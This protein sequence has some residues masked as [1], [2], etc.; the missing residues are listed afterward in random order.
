MRQFADLCLRP[1]SMDKPRI[2]RII[3][4]ASELGFSLVGISL[5]AKA[6]RDKVCFFRRVCRD[7]RADLVTR[8]DLTPSSSSELLRTLSQSRRKFELVAVKCFSKEVARQAAKDRR[9]DL[10][11]FPSRNWRDRFFDVAEAR[12]ASGGVAALEL[13]M[14]LV[15]GCEGS[16]WV[17]LL[18]CLREEVEVAKRFGVPLVI[19]S[20]GSDVLELRGPHELASLA[21]LVG[22]AS[23]EALDAVS[24]VP[25][26]IVKRNRE[27]LDENYVVEGVHVIKRGR[28]CEG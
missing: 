19:C 7:Y 8:I 12:L 11:V 5:P 15:W 2:E 20:G 6:E 24:E 9:V 16:A 27:K 10:L 4:K 26:N 3:C 25:Y 14:S 28:D 18:S 23:E 1:D 22:M 21:T 17:R 13:P